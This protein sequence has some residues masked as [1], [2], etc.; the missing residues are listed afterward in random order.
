ML[1]H[2]SRQI[3]PRLLLNSSACTERICHAGF[4][5]SPECTCHVGKLCLLLIPRSHVYF[6]QSATCSCRRTNAKRGT[7]DSC[8]RYVIHHA[9]C[10]KLLLFKNTAST[11]CCFCA[12]IDASSQTLFL[13]EMFRGLNLTLKAFFDR[14]VTVSLCGLQVWLQTHVA[15]S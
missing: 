10:S 14:K 9:L 8:R 4:A 3:V 1:R 2:T 7:K 12:V 11:S 5:S 15:A 6:A 13:T